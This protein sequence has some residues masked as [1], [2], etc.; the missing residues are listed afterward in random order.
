MECFLAGVNFLVHFPT[1][2]KNTLLR[3][4][5]KFF[6]S[7]FAISCTVPESDALLHLD[8]K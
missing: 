5:G 2:K 1:F 7:I 8:L 3:K 6:Y 4:G